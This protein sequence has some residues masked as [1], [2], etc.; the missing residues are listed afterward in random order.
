VRGLR[1][2]FGYKARSGKDTAAEYLQAQYGGEIFKF[3][4]PIY[5]IMQAAHK[6]A[7][8]DSFKDTKFLT[9]IGTDWGRSINKDLWVNN[10]I[11]RINAAQ[12]RGCYMSG[13][14]FVD[15][16]F[17][18]DMRFPNEAQALKNNGFL[19]V[20][21]DRD[22][23]PSE[24]RASHESENAMNDFTDWDVVVDNNGNIQEFY[25]Q[26]QNLIQHINNTKQYNIK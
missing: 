3:A 17:V 6:I 24:N 12:K 16:F 9:W 21:I 22:D 7:G 26:I 19:L 20:R 13:E 1:I 4:Q 8:I 15:N 10:C 23:R 5:D 11:D 14:P 25:N 18:T 2:A